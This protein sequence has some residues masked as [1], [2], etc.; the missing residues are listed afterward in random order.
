MDG[1][2]VFTEG[3]RKMAHTLQHVCRQAGI[4][5]EDLDRVV[6]HQ[7]NQRILN[8]VLRHLNLPK[9]RIYSNV[10][11]LGNTSSSTIPLCLAEII[12]EVQPGQWFGLTAFG[13][14]F[15]YGACLLK[16]LGVSA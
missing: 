6:P 12:P 3:V 14:G 4:A 11:Q 10:E 15:T 13:G 9:G 5:L 2:K 16:T 8:A 7:A 1:S